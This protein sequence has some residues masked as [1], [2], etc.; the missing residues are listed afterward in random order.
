MTRPSSSENSEKTSLT[1][2][3]VGPLFRVPTTPS[4]L[5]ALLD[6]PLAPSI[7]RQFPSVLLH[8]MLC[9]IGRADMV[10]VLALA[11][12]EQVREILD[13]EIWQGDRLQLDEALDWLCF[14]TT[15]PD[16]VRKRDL[17]ALDIEL[18]GYVLKQNTQIHLVEEGTLPDEAE[19]NLHGTPDGWFVLELTA[20]EQA[21]VQQTV[22][23]VDALYQDDPE[24]ARRLLHKLMGELPT[25]LEEWSLRWRNNRL[26]DLG[27]ADPQEALLLYAYLDP[28]SVHPSEGSVDRPPR[29]DPEP[30][31]G[32]ELMGLPSEPTSFWNKA[33]ARII[34]PTDRARLSDA[35]LALSNRALAAD[36]IHP[37]DLESGERSLQ[38]L[39]CRLSLGLEH[40]SG[41]DLERSTVALAGVGLLRI[42]RL[43]HSLV[44]DLRR[45]LMGPLREGKL[46]RQP[47]KADRLDPPLAQQIAA[48]CTPRPHYYEADTDQT[49]PFCTLQDLAV[50][51]KWVDQALAAAELVQHLELPSPLPTGATFGDL[52][53]T[54]MV[55]RCLSRQGPLDRPALQRF[56]RE[57]VQQGQLDLAVF[58]PSLDQTATPATQRLIEDWLRALKE[59]LGQL[60]P[61]QLDLRFVGGLWL[62]HD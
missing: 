58:P 9:S 32:K 6:D 20:Q 1:P 24:E 29:A 60:D 5:N 47:G 42:A 4:E 11:R 3:S 7:I 35:L 33:T 40:L 28:A 62:T 45:R 15:L 41:G 53:R 48:L 10:E 2:G 34:D 21:Q 55:N 26:E 49:R 16:E 14:L 25:E 50:A 37:A 23:L 30:S 36:R 61:N 22:A 17:K 31:L 56:L 43:G 54:A 27:F 12:P 13:L 52:Y 46:G 57:V 39:H 18:I 8:R 19:G 59:Q 51:R 38:A 44:L